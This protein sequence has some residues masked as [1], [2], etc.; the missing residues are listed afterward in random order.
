MD[1][2]FKNLSR[3]EQQL[4]KKYKYDLLRNKCIILKEKGVDACMDDERFDLAG[5]Y[6]TDDA[7]HLLDLVVPQIIDYKGLVFNRPLEGIGIRGFYYFMSLFYFVR[8]RQLAS[9]HD[10]SI[11]DRMLMRNI[12]TGDEIWLLNKVSQIPDDEVEMFM[13]D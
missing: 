4:V 1:F 12:L 10:G 7:R 6:I 9:F 2:E 13:E 8:K 3:K 11:I 5:V